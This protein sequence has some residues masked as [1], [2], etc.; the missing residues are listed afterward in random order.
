MIVF[1]VIF[2]FGKGIIENKDKKNIINNGISTTGEITKAYSR[3]GSNSGFINVTL[4]FCYNTE[5]GN[6]KTGKA[7]LVINSMDVNNYQPGKK[8]PLRYSKRD[9]NQ[10]VIDIPNPL[11]NR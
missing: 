8:V 11:L 5:D 7:D 10:V 1:F 2:F 3:S 9:V 6:K 4:E